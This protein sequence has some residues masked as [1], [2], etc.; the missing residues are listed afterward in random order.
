MHILFRS[1]FI[2]LIFV[3]STSAHKLSFTKEEQDYIKNNKTI[4]G[5]ADNFYPFSIEK[6][7]SKEGITVDILKLISKKSGL[8]IEFTSNNWPANIS[9][10]KNKKIDIITEISYTKERTKYINFTKPY[11][12]TALHLYSN[13]NISTYDGTL[14]SLKGKKLGL[15][16]NIFYEKE[17]RKLG[18]FEI[19]EFNSFSGQLLALEQNKVDLII[20]KFLTSNKISKEKEYTNIKV[21]DELKI[22]T[23]NKE[24]LRFGIHKDNA[25]LF[26]I[27][28]KTFNEI[29]QNELKE[30][31]EKWLGN[32]PESVNTTYEGDI[33]L[34]KK[35]LFYLKNKKVIKMCSNPNY[36]PIVF[37]D[38]TNNMAGIVVDTIK[39]IEKKLD[40]SIKIEHIKTSTFEELKKLFEDG[41][42]DVMTLDIPQKN[43][44]EYIYTNAYLK[45][46]PVFITRNTEPFIYSLN[47]IKY[48]GISKK[49]NPIAIKILK[50][51]FPGINI[52][53][54]KTE[55]EA[56]EKVSSGEVYSTVS[57]LPVASY[58]ISK[59][60]LSNLKI[61]GHGNTDI[62]FSMS[63]NKNDEILRSILNKSL[64]AITQREKAVIFNTWANIQYD[65]K[66]DFSKL[67]NIGIIILLI[68]IFLAYR[69]LIL[70]KTNKRLNKA[71]IELEESNLH[72]QTIFET[73]IESILISNKDGIIVDCNNMSCFLFG[74]CKKELIGMKIQKL[75][76]EFNINK[77]LKDNKL[78]NS[79]E[80]EIKRSN[81]RLIPVL[82]RNSSIIKN[83]EPHTVS[84]A[85]DLS[86]LKKTQKALET[87][88]KE[89]F[90]RVNKEV[91]KNKEKDLKLLQQARHAQMGELISMIAH[92]WRQP[93]NAVATTVMNME[94]QIACN[95]FDLD[96][97][98]DREDFLEF[99]NSQLSNIED[100]IQT[101]SATIDDFRNFYKPDK[102]SQIASV[103][104][105]INKT[106]A[107]TK[108]LI[109]S[110]HIDL[111]L[112][113]LSKKTIELYESELLQVFLNIIKNSQDNFEDRDINNP[114]ITINSEDTKDGVI[115]EIL[116]N[117]GGINPNIIDNIFDPYFSTKD[118]KN[119]TGLGL[120][121]SKTI[122]DEH[123]NG[124]LFVQ[125]LN[126]GV[127]FTIELNNKI[128]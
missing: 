103:N 31:K 65:T 82:I 80:I 123:H 56:F 120:Y 9:S 63:V 124:K 15:T 40:S 61:A 21:L 74:Y 101:L 36:A 12:E 89:L 77:E 91:E 14:L 7:G 126:D 76:K 55:K 107:I 81:G 51:Q 46:K 24:D 30:I 118:I 4:V 68:V 57:L 84:I 113:L 52:I 48:K 94:L 60:G 62:A 117:G 42:C 119:G 44:N 95:N 88:N 67:I 45:Y 58:N 33:S 66:F 13:K 47:E 102:E 6:N 64:N 41:I 127:C 105:T 1:I 116:D 5:L 78:N 115:I 20:G 92:Q 2:I 27:V 49:H 128:K 114:T 87:L 32:Y 43:Q 50:N 108:A 26:A 75:I 53:E 97:K 19:I 100:F 125:N 23:L 28:N 29:N 35:E 106:L 122:I 22:N 90:L 112:N 16:K 3:C 73:T 110:K 98:K 71:K 121:M 54:T 39:V 69:Q 10:L 18:L 17:I 83:N 11:F 86:K 79:N 37:L 109:L 38:K 104:G 85:L 96:D 99:M 93:L 111:E 72:F 59:Y 25:L 34:S 8:K 70:A